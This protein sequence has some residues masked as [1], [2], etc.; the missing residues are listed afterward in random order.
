MVRPA[1][2]DGILDRSPRPSRI[3]ASTLPWV[4]G[5]SLTARGEACRQWPRAATPAASSR[6]LFANTTRSAQAT[7][8]SKTSS[9]GSSW[10]SD[11]SRCAPPQGLEVRGDPASAKAARRRGDDAVDDDAAF[12][13]GHW[14]AWTSGS[15]GQTQGLDQDVVDSGLAR[16]VGRARAR[17]RRRPCSRSAIGQL[18]DFSSGQPSMPQPFRISPSMP[19]SPNS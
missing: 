19:T 10:S 3:G 8:S 4:D 13:A 6:S 5:T 18:D 11:Q 12:I 9:T 15:A 17:N 7:S 16:Q 14:K 1:A 2:V